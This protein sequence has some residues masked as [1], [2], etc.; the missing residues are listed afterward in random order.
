MSGAVY[1]RLRHYAELLHVPPGIRAVEIADGQLVHGG[2]AGAARERHMDLTEG[3]EQRAAMDK[4]REIVAE[5][6]RNGGALS[7][8]EVEASRALLRHDQR[9]S[10]G[11][12]T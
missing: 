5:F 12:T 1:E 6:E 10:G 2:E 7:R 8:E 11:A 4:L 3:H 9:R